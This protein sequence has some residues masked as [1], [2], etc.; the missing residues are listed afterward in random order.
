M[1]RKSLRRVISDGQ[2]TSPEL[3]GQS[4]VVMPDDGATGIW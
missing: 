4:R 1:L 3:Y 2:K